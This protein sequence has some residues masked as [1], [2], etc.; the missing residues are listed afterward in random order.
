MDRDEHL[1]RRREQYRL[2][3]SRETPED[4]ESRRRRNREYMRRQRVAMTAEQRR[5]ERTTNIRV[6]TPQPTPQNRELP[7]FNDPA[8]ITLKQT[9]KHPCIVLRFHETCTVCN[10]IITSLP[11]E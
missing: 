5:L 7:S 11:Y 9:T 2:R 1:R 6:T 3:R 10:M 8:I 4:A